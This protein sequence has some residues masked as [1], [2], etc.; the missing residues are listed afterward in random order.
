MKEDIWKG[1]ILCDSNYMIFWWRQN[2]GDRI[3]ISVRQWLG[4]R[5]EQ[6][7]HRRILRRGNYS[8]WYCNGEHMPGICQSP[9]TLQNKKE[10]LIQTLHFNSNVSTLACN[11][12]IIVMQDIV[13]RKTVWDRDV[14]SPTGTLCSF[15]ST[16]CNWKTVLEQSL[17][18]FKKC[19]QKPLE[20]ASLG[21]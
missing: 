19:M 1:Y 14:R 2:Y 18:I 7:Q 11:K 8:A 13:I 10:T 3:K 15:S 16:S 20:M 9:Q 4:G 12:Y 17:L 5:D 21:K 6:A